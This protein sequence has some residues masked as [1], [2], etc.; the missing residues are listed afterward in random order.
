MRKYIILNAEPI[1]LWTLILKEKGCQCNIKQT[2]YIENL[3]KTLKTQ[4]ELALFRNQ[5]K[6]R[7]MSLQR[8][9]EMYMEQ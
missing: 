1:E 2:L 9:R 8:L 4:I 3:P 5:I 6:L 7:A